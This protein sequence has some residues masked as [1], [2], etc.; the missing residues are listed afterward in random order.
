MSNEQKMIGQRQARQHLETLYWAGVLIWAGL[1]FGADRLGFLPQIGKADPWTWVF[2]GAGLYALVGGIFR[3]LSPNW[4]NPTTWDYIWAGILL[5][6]SIG[7]FSA[8]E[9]TW[10]L[11]LVF[12]GLVLLG[13][14][15]LGRS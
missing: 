11:V 15:L 4:P 12:V 2:F 1:V 13:S 10:S 8:L 7:G 9:I 14:I 6:I 5:I 3:L